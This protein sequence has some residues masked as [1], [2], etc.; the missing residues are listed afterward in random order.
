MTTMAAPLTPAVVQ[1]LAHYASTLLDT[2]NGQRTAVYA[3]AGAELG[4]SVGTV[5]RRMKEVA[6]TSTRPPRRRRRDAGQS[7]LSREEA[8]WLSATLLEHIRKNNKRLVSVEQAVEELRANGVIKAE[9]VDGDGVISRMSAG[10]IAQALRMYTLH[11]D[12]LLAAAPAIHQASR[13]PNHVWQIDASRCVLF[14]LPEQTDDSGLRML[15]YTHYQEH[16]KNKPREL[17]KV[18]QESLWRYVV[19][20]HAS[21]CVFTWYVTG[22]ET[23]GNL[24]EAFIQAM[25]PRGDSPF[26]GVPKMVMLDPGG[27][28]T[29]PPFLNLCKTLRVHV[30]INKPRNPRAKGQVENAQ[31]LVEKHFESRFRLMRVGTLDQINAAALKWERWFNTAFTHSRHGMARYEAFQ[32][33]TAEQLVLAPGVDLCRELTVSAALSR[34]VNTFLEVEYEGQTWDV[35]QV[36]GVLVGQSLLI[37]RNAWRPG[38]AQAVGVGEDGHEVYHVLP[39]KTASGEFGFMDDAQMMG[40]GHQRHADTL[41]QRHMKEVEQLATGTTSV[42]EA[43]AA[44]KAQRKGKGIVPLGGRV[45]PMKRINDAVLPAYLPRPGQTLEVRNPVA[46]APAE[47]VATGQAI[48]RIAKAIGRAVTRDENQFIRGR[49]PQEMPAEQVE[50]LVA[51]FQRG[52][53]LEQDP[54]AAAATFNGL[55][56]VG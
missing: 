39:L 25:H 40:E 54:A 31:N 7:A 48:A 4:L 1:R 32:R 42:S 14:Y 38:S 35:S 10:A 19:T 52:A 50:A 46:A 55:R 43:E 5:I 15:R 3:A 34:K 41:A 13:H 8:L 44:R 56:A 6:V 24:A 51:Q 27:A 47:T 26:H 22:G 18:I 49:W 16:Y 23:G 21:G 33:I 2:P 36:P 30:Q 45:D 12:Q 11:P 28:N 53:A 17:V 20:D 37:V 29:S 9:R